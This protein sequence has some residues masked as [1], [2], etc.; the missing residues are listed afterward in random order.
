MT[1]VPLP[2]VDAG[3]EALFR[4]GRVYVDGDL[5]R[6]SMP[7]GPWLG[8]PDGLTSAGSLG[9][10]VDNVLGYAIIASRPPD[11]WSV[12][13]E[14][15]LDVVSDLAT[16]TGRLHA[17]ASTVHADPIGGFAIGR[18]YDEAGTLVASCT[19]RGRFVPAARATI[20][21]PVLLDEIDEAT[22]LAAL[23]ELD[24]HRLEITPRLQNPMRNLH[25]G[26]AITVSDLVAAAALAATDGP[27]LV[28]A[29]IHMAFLR[30]TPG[31][32]HAAYTADVLHRGRTSA[33]V[34][35]VG[36]VSGRVCTTA[37]VAAHPRHG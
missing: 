2:I 29:S 13:T 12:S 16:A 4:V 6:G 11:H 20:E 8:G 15:T 7:V 37:R 34:D 24:D 26:I 5:V 27:P 30:P 31:G 21:S 25:G 10:L 14:I 33:L 18:V 19:Q 1:A 9:V 23:L 32:A 35:V 17:E 28:T 36:T 22:D 3:P